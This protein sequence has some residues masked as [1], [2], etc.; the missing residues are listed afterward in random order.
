MVEERRTKVSNFLKGRA[1]E[2]TALI[3]KKSEKRRG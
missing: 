3:R 1:G 2:D